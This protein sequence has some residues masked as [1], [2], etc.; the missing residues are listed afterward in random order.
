MNHLTFVS[1]FKI[2]KLHLNVY[3][4]TYIRLRREDN[5]VR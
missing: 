3:G 5:S 2:I 4:G 1:Y